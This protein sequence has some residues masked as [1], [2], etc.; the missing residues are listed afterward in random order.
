MQLYHSTTQENEAA[1][2]S[3]GACSCNSVVPV[4]RLRTIAWLFGISKS[5]LCVIVRET[6]EAI[7]Q[8]Q[9]IKL[10]KGDILD[11]VIEGFEFRWGF[12]NCV[13]AVDG[14][15]IPPTN[16]RTDY[17]NRKGS[18]SIILQ[19]LVDFKYLLKDICWL[20]WQSA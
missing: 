11:Q 19:R 6:Y 13:G 10:P 4:N 2:I 20:A 3:G 16:C 5:S 7:L 17:Y 14:T 8:N 9:M 15:H 18:Y 1:Y 12:P